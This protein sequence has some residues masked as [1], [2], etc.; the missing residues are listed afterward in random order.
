MN[1]VFRAQALGD[2]LH[3][4][5][6]GDVLADITGYRREGQLHMALLA[7]PPPQ[8]AGG[9]EHAVG[10]ALRTR[11]GIAID[12]MRAESRA[13]Q[14]LARIAEDL[15]QR[16]ID[17]DDDVRVVEQRLADR[18]VLHGCAETQFAAPIRFAHPCGDCLRLRFGPRQRQRDSEQQQRRDDAD[19]QRGPQPRSASSQD[20]AGIGLEIDLPPA[21]ERIEELAVREHV[22]WPIGRGRRQVR[23]QHLRPFRDVDNAQ[24]DRSLS[25]AER[26]LYELLDTE[27]HVDPSLQRIAPRPLRCGYDSI[28]IDGRIHQQGGPRETGVLHELHQA[29]Q[30]RFA[31]VACSVHRRTPNGLRIHVVADRGDVLGR[32][33]FEIGHRPIALAN[34]WR[35]HGEEA[36][37]GI[38]HRQLQ[39]LQLHPVQV[40][41][42]SQ[43]D[44]RWELLLDSKA[45]D[46]VVPLLG[47]GLRDR[48]EQRNSPARHQPVAGE[49]ILQTSG[50]LDGLGDE[51]F[52]GC[53]R[54]ALLGIAP[55]HP[56]QCQR[57]QQCQHRQHVALHRRLRVGCPLCGGKR[58]LVHR[59]QDSRSLNPCRVSGHEPRERACAAVF[60]PYTRS[61]Q[62]V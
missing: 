9:A 20:C 28:A 32:P 48:R 51:F 45:R 22:I 12:E 5:Q 7:V 53:V 30:P 50:D 58:R 36:A 16:R 25:A 40:G 46:I 41:G 34:A 11:R 47:A 52:P 27:R 57:G 60:R 14:A 44:Q 26:D 10:R 37:S 39:V 1:P 35:M 42:K 19:D 56:D 3:L 15:D 8:L 43:A 4:H 54:F 33:R 13:E 17:V 29:G 38:P 6:P 59:F 23:V 62:R 31:L 21:T 55:I 49:A 61:C 2:V 18:R 24:G